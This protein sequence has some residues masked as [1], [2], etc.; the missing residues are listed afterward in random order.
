MICY[1][2]KTLIESDKAV[3]EYFSVSLQNLALPWWCQDVRSS[4]VEGYAVDRTT[5]HRC[6]AGRLRCE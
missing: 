1:S 2:V 4:S 6:D 5:L 3:E